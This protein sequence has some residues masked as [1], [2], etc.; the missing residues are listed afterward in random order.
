MASDYLLPTTMFYLYLNWRG[1]KAIITVVQE[2]YQEDNIGSIGE[3]M[4][5]ARV[6]NDEEQE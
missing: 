3:S 1:Y 4:I 5:I 6:Q 2:D